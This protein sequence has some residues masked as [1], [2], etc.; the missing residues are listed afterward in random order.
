MALFAVLMCVNFA[1]CSNEND[2][3]STEEQEFYTV[4]LGW[5]GE[6]LDITEEPLSRTATAD[7]YGIQIYSTPN[8][9]LAEGETPIWTAYAYGL[10]EDPSNISANLLKGYKYKFVAT[11][12]KDGK[13]KLGAYSSPFMLVGNATT[14]PGTDFNY[15][16]HPY[17]NGLGNGYTFTTNGQYY[18]FNSDRYYGELVD[19][20]P[21]TSQIAT[22]PMKRTAF[23]ASFVAINTVSKTGKL[24]IMM[25]SA[26]KMEIEFVAGE[27]DEFW[28]KDIFTFYD[29]AAAYAT[30]GYTE[31][32]PV[33]FN[34]HRDDGGTIPLGTHNITYKRNRNT[35]VTIKIKNAGTDEAV[36]FS[37][38]GTEQVE[39]DDMEQDG[40]TT[41]EDGEIVT[42]PV[43]PTN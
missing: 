38:A 14:I 31:T 41:I 39:I 9:D 28:A 16:S 5:D 15:A 13:N 43:T 10:F 2:T 40:N 23:G 35:I 34:W 26:P 24:E 8:K 25:Q 22:I 11:M 19:Y 7:L 33:T 4:K 36:G 37:I 42:T 30:D 27:I 3:P 29:V 1:S 21:A 17:F 6:I 18:H 12:V 20:D 32:I